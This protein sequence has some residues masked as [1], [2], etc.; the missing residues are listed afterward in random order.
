MKGKKE[1]KRHFKNKRLEGVKA[2]SFI[3]LKSQ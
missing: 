1:N 3:L 2:M